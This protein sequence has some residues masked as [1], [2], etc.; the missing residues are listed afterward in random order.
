MAHESGKIGNI[1]LIRRNRHFAPAPAVD[2]AGGTDPA[3][4]VGQVKEQAV[5]G[6]PAEIDAASGSH[7]PAPVRCFQIQGAV[8]DEDAALEIRIAGPRIFQ[9]MLDI[10]F[11]LAVHHHMDRGPVDADRRYHAK[12]PSARQEAQG[13]DRKRQNRYG[14]DQGA[15]FVAQRCIPHGKTQIRARFNLFDMQFSIDIGF[16]RLLDKR[17]CLLQSSGKYDLPDRQMDTGKH[18]CTD[19][20]PFLHPKPHPRPPHECSNNSR[21]PCFQSTPVP[22]SI[23][24][25][26]SIKNADMGNSQT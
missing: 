14:S 18:D 22:F 9:D 17:L 6:I 26:G 8:L 10:P 7:L 24:D 23:S 21:K 15:I 12:S 1:Q 3:V 11:V 4:L 25:Y 2:A 13:I 5:F 19:G 16:C 20:Q